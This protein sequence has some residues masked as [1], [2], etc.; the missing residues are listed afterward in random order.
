MIANDSWTRVQYVAPWSEG[1]ASEAPSVGD[2]IYL[3][4]G[5]ETKYVD[6]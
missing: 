4:A 6:E 1:L 3:K 2:E 5:G